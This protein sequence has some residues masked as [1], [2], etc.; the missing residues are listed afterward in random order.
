MARAA[1][2][3]AG[4]KRLVFEVTLGRIPDLPLRYK[5]IAMLEFRSFPE[6]FDGLI[7]VSVYREREEFG[8]SECLVSNFD[9][10]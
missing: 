9:Q 10:I 3:L 1:R 6:T 2:T 7:T 5:R 4:L 8:C